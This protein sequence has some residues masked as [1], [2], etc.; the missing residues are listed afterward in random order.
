MTDILFCVIPKH[1]VNV[2][3]LAIAYLQGVCKSHGFR[4]DVRDFNLEL[5]KK[6]IHTEW[7]EIWKESNETLYK[8]EKFYEFYKNI[9]GEYIEKWAKEIADHSAPFIG[10]SCFSYRSLPTL[11]YLSPL[12]KK[13]NPNKKIIVGGSPVF[14]YHKWIIDNNLADYAVSNEGE[15]ALLDILRNRH[16]S[17]H[18]I[19]P[20]IQNLNLLPYPDYTGFNFKDYVPR[21]PGGLRVRD[22]N[23]QRD[24]YEAGIMGSRGCV[25]RCTFCDVESFYPKFRWRSAEHIYNEMLYLFDNGI[26]HIYFFDSLINGNQK[27]LEKLCDLIIEDG[28]KFKSIKGLGIIKQMP[29]RLYKKLSE[30]N[31][32]Q[33]MIGIE[34]FS[35]KLR[36]D[37]NKGFTDKLLKQNLDMYAKYKINIALL[38]IVGYP[39]QT[40]EDHLAEYYWMKENQ[41]YAGNPVVRI[42]IGGTMLILPG[43]PVFKKKMYDL[44]LDKNKDWVSFP[45]RESNTMEVRVRRRQEIEKWAND[46]GFRVGSTYG[47]GGQ[48]IGDPEKNSIADYERPQDDLVSLYHSDTDTDED[49]EFKKFIGWESDPQRP[50]H[51]EE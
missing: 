3:P 22:K 45:N 46:F 2:P 8:G 19:K 11:K 50:T 44:Y 9:Y 28:S 13:Y 4:T 1:G 7:W 36:Q 26:N 47:D 20:Q 18:V 34:S 24:S 15:D 39:T 10:I 29:E 37:M 30:A 21:D 33:I 49:K 6:T 32:K 42:E 12:I 51:R 43:A 17:R 31:F 41:K 25:R 35:P 16:K 48:M 14:T 38:L 5:W 23:Y 40:E 27:E